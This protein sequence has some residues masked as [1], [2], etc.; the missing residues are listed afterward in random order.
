VK[1]S[2]FIFITTTFFWVYNGSCKPKNRVGAE[3][4]FRP[5]LLKHSNLDMTTEYKLDSVL[6]FEWDRMIILTP[7]F[8]KKMIE[9]CTEISIPSSTLDVTEAANEYI[10]IKDRKIKKYL[11][12][13]NKEIENIAFSFDKKLFS[14]N[15]TQFECGIIN[16]SNLYIKLIPNENLEWVG[17]TF[18]IFNK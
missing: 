12:S 7:Y 17:K 11:S 8:N 1:F 9:K 3:L 2:Y 10:F 16:D 13:K 6:N 14:K 5:I 18:L 15:E 4:I